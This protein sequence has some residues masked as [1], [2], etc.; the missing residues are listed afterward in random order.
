[1]PVIRFNML[2]SATVGRY[3]CRSMLRRCD[4]ITFTL[5]AWRGLRAGESLPRDRHATITAGRRK[6]AR[7]VMMLAGIIGM[8]HVATA[9]TTSAPPNSLVVNPQQGAT[10]QLILPPS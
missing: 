9:Q 5:S 3:G 4:T 7:I 2:R 1:M 6:G 8:D 10:P